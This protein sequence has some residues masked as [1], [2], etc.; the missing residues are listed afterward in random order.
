MTVTSTLTRVVVPAQRSRR[1][2]RRQREDGLVVQVNRPGPAEFEVAGLYDLGT[3]SVPQRL[4]LLEYLVGLGATIDDLVAARPGELPLVASRIALWGDRERL[5]FDEVAA[6]ANI[7][8]ELVAHA[9]RAAG[10]PEPDPDPDVLTF[11][12]HDVEILAGLE[13]GIELLG[14]P[15]TIQMIRVLGAA[16]ARVADASVSAFVV[17]IGP[18]AVE[19]EPAGLELAQA[20]AES[21]VLVDSMSR[22][23][24]SFLRHHIDRAFRPHEAME[25]VAGIDLVRRSIGFAD[26]VNSTAWTQQLDLPALSQALSLF[27]STA[28]E[29]VVGRGGRVVKLIGDEVM[30]VAH[31]PAIGI[32]IALTLVDAFASHDVL[33]PVRTGVA[34][35][36]VLAR[37]GDYSGPV[38]NLAAR[39]VSVARPSTLLVDTETLSALEGS[40]DFSSRPA[41]AFTLKGFAQRVKLSRVT[42]SA[43]R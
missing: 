43:S 22:A 23:F 16:A 42:R 5:N 10:F 26:L 17:N 24:D 35:G 13:A 19:H 30:F 27:D 25:A 29:I 2:Q 18:Q 33:P 36:D 20:N 34:T 3:D 38:V 32:D 28:S 31:D 12:R 41:G 1:A 37:D 14:E 8:P 6:A 39:A 4:A 9:W 40:T 7:A 11:S 21:V 15:V